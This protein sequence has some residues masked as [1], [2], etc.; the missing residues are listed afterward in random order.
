MQVTI[1][2]REFCEKYLTA[3]Q[4]VALIDAENDYVYYKGEVRNILSDETNTTYNV[5]ILRIH[6]YNTRV[7]P[8]TLNNHIIL[9]I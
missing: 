2:V 6:S 9:V 8:F 3:S 4:K 5:R 1:T 7:E